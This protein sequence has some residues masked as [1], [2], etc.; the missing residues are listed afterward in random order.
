MIEEE[1]YGYFK[2][3]ADGVHW[4]NLLCHGDMTP[5]WGSFFWYI[6]VYSLGGEE[7]DCVSILEEGVHDNHSQEVFTTIIKT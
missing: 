5:K 1:D 2:E 4:A 3:E 7:V 6:Y